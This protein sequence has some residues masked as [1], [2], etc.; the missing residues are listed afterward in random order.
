M[1]T[2]LLIV[3]TVLMSITLIVV[4]VGIVVYVRRLSEA[5][6]EVAA[7]ARE[8]AESVRIAQGAIVPLADDAR[9]AVN[10]ADQL[11]TSARVEVD[12][13]GRITGALEG[14]LEGRS[15]V[16]AAGRAVAGSRSTA[17]AVLDGVKEALKTLR[18]SR[19]G[20]KEDADNG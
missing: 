11:M 12:S 10:N 19:K 15:I 18:S 8:I 20:T 16:N 17:V 14:L 2:T 9:R 1:V 3:L 7:A 6:S 4:A 13:I 5:S